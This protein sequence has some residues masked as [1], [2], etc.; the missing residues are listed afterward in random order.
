MRSHIH[1]WSSLVI[2]I[3]ALVGCQNATLPIQTVVSP[4]LTAISLPTVT[5]STLGPTLTPANRTSTPTLTSQP[6]STPSATKNIV[7]PIDYS[8]VGAIEPIGA[9]FVSQVAQ[10]QMAFRQGEVWVIIPNQL[11]ELEIKE[12]H[13]LAPVTMLPN[14]SN[15]ESLIVSQDGHYLAAVN[16]VNGT[17]SLWDLDALQLVGTL[18]FQGYYSGY[19]LTGEFSPDNKYLAIGGC[20]LVRIALPVCQSS[21]VAIYELAT[22]NL[23]QEIIGYQEDTWKVIFSPSGDVLAASGKKEDILQADLLIWNLNLNAKQDTITF[24]L[25]GTDEELGDIAFS[26]SEEKMASIASSRGG[27]SAL[28]LWDVE[29]WTPVTNCGPGHGPI[30]VRYIPNTFLLVTIDGL[31][32]TGITFWNTKTCEPIRFIPTLIGGLYNLVVS[33]NGRFIYTWSDDLSGNYK[34]QEWGVP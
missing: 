23:F 18:V 26:Q 5:V 21:G 25:N 10:A 16:P 30:A 12:F 20:R 11:G 1:T 6:T 7:A 19:T 17:I 34:I 28:V 4:T 33:P 2:C 27:D 13:S 9:P 3:I 29:T 31:S 15:V 32:D 8:N 14:A 22:M 24:K